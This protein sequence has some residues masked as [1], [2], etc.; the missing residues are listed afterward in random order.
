MKKETKY[1]I[2][3]WITMILYAIVMFYIFSHPSLNTTKCLDEYSCPLPPG[4]YLGSISTGIAGIIIA[5]Y[6]GKEENSDIVNKLDNCTIISLI[7]TVVAVILGSIGVYIM[8]NSITPPY[9]I[10]ETQKWSLIIIISIII[11]LPIIIVILCKYL[12]KMEKKEG[13]GRAKLK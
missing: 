3:L 12:E 7:I 1:S 5:Y 4:F 6:S 10:T 11:I 8:S 9:N 2:I 13:S